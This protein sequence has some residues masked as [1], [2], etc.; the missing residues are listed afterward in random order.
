MSGERLPNVSVYPDV[1]S[2][3]RAAAEMFSQVADRAIAERK[4]LM[5]AISGGSTPKRLF[6]I[7]S[8][9]PYA[10]GVAWERIH[11]FWCDERLV[12]AEHPESN[13]GQAVK[14]LFSQI[15]VPVENLHRMR[16]EAPPAKAVDEYRKLLESFGEDDLK[17][18]RLD[19][20]FLGLGAD[21]HTASLFPGAFH[22]EEMDSPVVAVTAD[23]QGRPSG[24]VTL[25]PLA[26]NSARNVIFMVSGKDKANAVSET[27]T[28]IN[29]LA[30]WPAKR[31]RP[32]DGKLIWM[33]DDEAASQFMKLKGQYKEF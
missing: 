13:F 14:W 32:V 2:L 1:D 8:R 19:L 15:N 9:P 29:N 33:L 31:I 7:L 16:G 28:G 5:V 6:Q 11:F 12:P 27:L 10:Q 3:S 18:P 4:R 20:A 26:L 30:K 22:P 23:Y 24:R 25:T 21:G 17:W